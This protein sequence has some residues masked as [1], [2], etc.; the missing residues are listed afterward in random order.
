MSESIVE[1]QCPRCGH[2][3]DLDIDTL[4]T[5]HQVVDKDPQQHSR[6]ESY[7]VRGPNHDTYIVVDVESE[8]E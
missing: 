2:A 5:P 6:V 1:V 8:R 7:R 4:G 3:W